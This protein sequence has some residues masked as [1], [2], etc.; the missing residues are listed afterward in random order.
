MK[1]MKDIDYYS[2]NNLN[3]EL[4]VDL[5]VVNYKNQ[6]DGRNTMINIRLGPSPFI[7][8]IAFLPPFNILIFNCCKNL[9]IILI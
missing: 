6:S 5:R 7:Y 8:G 2:K 9:Y 3:N 4:P 1:I